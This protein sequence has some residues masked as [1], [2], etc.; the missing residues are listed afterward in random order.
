[1]SCTD[2][3]N[4]LAD[5]GE[6]DRAIAEYQ[7]AVELEPDNAAALNN[8]GT[9]LRDSGRLDAAIEAYH[10]AVALRPELPE[11]YNN[12]AVALA[13]RGEFEMALAACRKAIELRPD[14]IEANAN[15]GVILCDLG[16]EDLAVEVCRRAVALQP[17]HAIAHCNLA[18]VLLRLGQYEEGFRENEW[19]FLC[20]PKY[21]ARAFDQPIWD[22]RDLQGKRILLYAEQGFGDAIQFARYVPLVG[23]QGG[24]VILECQPELARLFGSLEGVSKIVTKGEV[25][26]GFDV[27]CGLM[28]LPWKMGTRLE[29]VPAPIP[30]LRAG[31]MERSRRCLSNHAT[32]E[33]DCVFRVGLAWAG[34]E[35]HSNDRNRSMKFAE[36]APV[37][38]ITKLEFHS[39]QKIPGETGGSPVIDHSKAL[40][41]FAATAELIETL[42]LVISVD[43]A[44]AHLAGAMGKPVWVML[45]FVPDWRWMTGRGDSPWYPTMR[46]FR[47][48][49]WGDWGGVVEE[50]K[51]NLINAVR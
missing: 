20:N 30:Y 21:R 32:I 33:P 41:D 8:L 27:H 11:S 49:S 37:M 13:D 39:L 51:C 6:L 45:P 7:R 36:L 1:M 47:Q 17:D 24:E 28:S 34:K 19:R 29:T 15:L 2:R 4:A 5:S 35:T 50:I 23:R 40:T 22:G 26:P 25:L 14:Y 3:G 38:A 44:V 10:R 42:D 12:L 46:L 31:G 9:V 18:L 16:A 48:S 43:T